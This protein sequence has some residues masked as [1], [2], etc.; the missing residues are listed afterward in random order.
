M[1]ILILVP[2]LRMD[3]FNSY[4]NIPVSNILRPPNSLRI[5]DIS[6]TDLRKNAINFNILFE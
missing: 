3:P 5:Y 1:V 6:N 4:E 2:Y